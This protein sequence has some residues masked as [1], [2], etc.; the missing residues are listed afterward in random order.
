[1]VTTTTMLFLLL[2]AD[3]EADAGVPDQP[4][5]AAVETPA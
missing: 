5:A 1:M 3:A 4:P 2:G